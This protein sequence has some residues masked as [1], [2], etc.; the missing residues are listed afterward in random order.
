V[1]VPDGDWISA[2][3][4]G[5]TIADAT[6]ACFAQDLPYDK[7]DVVTLSWQK[8]LGGEGGHGMLI[9]GPRAVDRLESYVPDRPLPKLFRMTKAGKLNEG[10][11]R[12]ETI[13]TPSM[14]V[15]EDYIFGLEWAIGAGGLSA[16]I[17]RC[18]ANAAALDRW[19][20]QTEWVEHLVADPAVRSNTSVCLQFA[21]SAVPG[22][23]EEA[24]RALIK[25]MEALLE[26]EG[27]AYDVAGHRDAPA[28]IRIWCGATVESADIEV[29]G[30]WLDWAFHEA[31]SA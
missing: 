11:F 20:A 21:T 17:A 3:R 22:Y 26:A 7:L 23:D 13:N 25:K 15:V 6:S 24:K 29:L 8:V 18:D 19:V 30:P 12:G 1:C 4:E 9:L 31:R 14:L 2:D 10:I 16:L 27:A 5:L 28:G